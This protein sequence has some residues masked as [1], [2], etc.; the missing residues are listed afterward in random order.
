MVNWNN[1][2]IAERF[3]K[4]FMSQTIVACWLYWG[5]NSNL[6][7]RVGFQRSKSSK[8]IWNLKKKNPCLHY[9]NYWK[10]MFYFQTWFRIW[11]VKQLMP[12]MFRFLNSHVLNKFLDLQLTVAQHV[13]LWVLLGCFI[14]LWMNWDGAEPSESAKLFSSLFLFCNVI[15]GQ[16]YLLAFP[17]LFSSFEEQDARVK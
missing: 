4:C 14:L 6:L 17:D 13:Q 3:T 11:R 9:S 5:A 7:Q 2:W 12:T 8:L 16:V 15:W 10:V 1:K